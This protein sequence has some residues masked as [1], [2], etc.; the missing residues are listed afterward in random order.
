MQPDAGSDGR[1]ECVEHEKKKRGSPE[2]EGRDS[3]DV[4]A[5]T[6]DLCR[7][8]REAAN[9]NELTKSAEPYDARR[10]ELESHATDSS[11]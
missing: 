4:R 10:R 9:E 11:E 1:S 3:Y 8:E 5:G 6:T 2:R 7:D